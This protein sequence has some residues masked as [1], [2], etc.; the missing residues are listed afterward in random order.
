M[1]FEKF[2]K[3]KFLIKDFND[4]FLTH[5]KAF[6]TANKIAQN[7]YARKVRYIKT[8]CYDARKNG[9]E[10]H[11]QLGSIRAK[12][13]KLD[14]VYLTIEEY[15]KILNTDF[16]SESLNNVRDWLIV[17]TET[18][19]R[20][21]DFM[22]FT[23]NNI[24][25]DGEDS[26]IEFTQKKT[27]KE[28]N[29]FVTSRL[30]KLL[31]SNNGNFPRPISSAK[32]NEYIKTVCKISGLTE[33]CKGA[34][35][36]KETKIREVGTFPKYKLISSK[37]GRKTFASY[38]FGKLPNELIMAQTGH[39]TESS[40]LFYVGKTHTSMAKQLAIAMKKLQ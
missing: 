21:S 29:V 7:T 24:R 14:I 20:I 28:M 10:T 31:N 23:K 32:F 9:I 35:T 18:A 8:I 38:Y 39:V 27:K 17:C 15:E 37:I 2:R 19:Q 34:L 30:S 4:D 33:K 22:D 13:E 3:T 25:F 16:K 11:Y 26:F 1:K 36:N 12:N 5:F 6:C 40:F